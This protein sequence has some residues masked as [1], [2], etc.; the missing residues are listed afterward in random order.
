VSFTTFSLQIC[1]LSKVAAGGRPGGLGT[2]YS[3]HAREGAQARVGQHE[4]GSVSQFRQKAT[5]PVQT[6]QGE[7]LVA[8]TAPRE[9]LSAGRGGLR[10]S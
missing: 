3:L 2:F 6:E 9:R 8:R 4:R 5:A 1:D 7:R 10:A